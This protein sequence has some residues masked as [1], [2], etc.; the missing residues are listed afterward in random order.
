MELFNP[1]KYWEFF[2]EHELD[3]PD[4]V[5]FF[6]DGKFAIHRGSCIKPQVMLFSANAKLIKSFEYAYVF[7]NGYILEKLSN[8]ACQIWYNGSPIKKRGIVPV[9]YTT[10]RTF[11][12]AFSYCDE[13]GFTVVLLCENGVI[14]Y[15]SL[16]REAID[17][18]S[19][20]STG[21]VLATTTPYGNDCIF[22]NADGTRCDFSQSFDHETKF[23]NHGY[24]IRST[25]LNNKHHETVLYSGS[26]G[27]ISPL[28]KDHVVYRSACIIDVQTGRIVK[29]YEQE[30]NIFHKDIFLYENKLVYKDMRSFLF[31]GK[32]DYFEIN[33]LSYIG[34]RPSGINHFFLIP[35]TSYDQIEGVDNFLKKEEDSVYGRILS[36]VLLRK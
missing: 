32:V 5:I 1:I 27:G 22:F 23:L 17:I 30:K 25:A 35:V 12:N 18:I 33:G 20:S 7:N 29:E 3:S 31:D 6:P 36:Q 8:D 15:T 34:Y 26:V 21:Q 16:P 19:I 2:A 28:G 9:S 4:T 24:F 14:H 13:N 10:L 11:G